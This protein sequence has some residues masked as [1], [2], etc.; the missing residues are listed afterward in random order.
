MLDGL[1]H[2]KTGQAPKTDE[3]KF[4][5]LKKEY[6]QKTVSDPLNITNQPSQFHKKT[7]LY[8]GGDLKKKA[9]GER[10]IGLGS[11]AGGASMMGSR[12]N[13][14]MSRFGA[15]S[16]IMDVETSP[17]RQGNNSPGIKRGVG[18]ALGTNEEQLNINL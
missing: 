7:Q 1:R 3:R 13:D 15:P 17:Q 14:T 5:A 2:L 10:K 4:Y 12:M 9:R 18:Y 16:N 8:D 11:N 6:Q